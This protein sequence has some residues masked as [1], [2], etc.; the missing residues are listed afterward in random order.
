MFPSRSRIATSRSGGLWRQG[1]WALPLRWLLTRPH[2]HAHRIGVWRSEFSSIGD[3]LAVISAVRCTVDDP[4]VAG[5]PVDLQRF[6][7]EKSRVGRPQGNS[8]VI[9]VR[10]AR[11][12][13]PHGGGNHGY[14]PPSLDGTRGEIS[15]RAGLNLPAT[16][17][18]RSDE[19]N[20][21]PPLP[22]QSRNS[23]VVGSATEAQNRQRESSR[24]VALPEIADLFSAN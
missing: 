10:H 2:K 21:R 13:G 5:V 12:C 14:K 19:S 16:S 8:H 11:F 17:A 24:R 22:Y 9:S 1:P 18:R 3:W 6:I 15:F 20:R 7:S 4:A 23:N